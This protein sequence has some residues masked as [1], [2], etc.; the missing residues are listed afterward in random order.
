M[1]YICIDI[2]GTSIKYG[3]LREDLTLEYTASR[4]TE[5]HLGGAGIMEKIYAVIEE[6][7]GK[8]APA[9]VCVSTAGMVD[10]ETGSIRYANELIP[11]YTGTPIKA[12]VER[13]FG[14]PCEVEND[15]NCAGLAEAGYGAARDS[16]TA[17]CLTVGT[18]IGGCILSDGRIFRGTG[19]AGSVGYLPLG[20]GKFEQLAA[21]SV[22]TQ[23]VA[24]EK[25]MPSIT[26]E[27]IF[28]LA[29]QGDE[30]CKKEIERMVHWLSV[31]ISA[32]CYTVAP[33]TVVL[34]G[35]IMAQKQLLGPML[36]RALDTM[37]VPSVREQVQLKFAEYEN[38]AGM[39][40]AL[41]HFLQ[42]RAG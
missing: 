25:N 11:G 32:I 1:Q 9:G 37:L 7:K 31:G 14:L 39:V 17:V 27:Q 34:G 41:C 40:G 8:C 23:R 2:G 33:D 15:V 29:E 10:C 38:H 36:N 4:P 12:N 35:G 16:R 30:V 42:R 19:T 28:A 22:L 3:I 18:G 21:T 20:E 24:H 26:G 6:C 5:A 13:R